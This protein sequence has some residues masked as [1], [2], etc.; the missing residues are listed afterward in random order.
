MDKEECGLIIDRFCKPYITDAVLWELFDPNK[1]K[2][3]PFL[4]AVGNHHYVLQEEFSTQRK[5]QQHFSALENNTDNTNIRE[6]LYE[7]ISNVI[8][9]E[10]KESNGQQF[11][12]RISMES[13]TSFRHLD[14]NIQQQLK[15]MYSDY[16]F[17][18][19]DDFW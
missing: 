15:S 17:K 1:D 7:L 5:V 19:Q 12:F 16:F 4:S 6:G 3:L 14:A 11:H 13:I 2:F 9:F 8:L 10:V 18:R